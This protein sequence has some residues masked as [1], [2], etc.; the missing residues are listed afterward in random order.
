MKEQSAVVKQVEADIKSLEAQLKSSAPAQEDGTGCRT[1]AAKKVLLEEKGALAELEKQF[2]ATAGKEETLRTQIAKQKQMMAGMTEG[3]K[4]P[5]PVCKGWENC[6]TVTA[7]F[8]HSGT[9]P[10]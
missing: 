9:H 5:P 3:T 2:A 8:Q 1:W 10:L 7:I 6:K 4:E